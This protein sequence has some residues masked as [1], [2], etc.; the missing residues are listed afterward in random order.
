MAV[1]NSSGPQFDNIYNKT[2]DL[3]AKLFMPMYSES[4]D[5]CEYRNRNNITY[6]I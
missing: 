6:L 2:E 4:S 1:R 3:S 5:K